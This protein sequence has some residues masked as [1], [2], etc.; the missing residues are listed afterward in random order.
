LQA[1]QSHLS[2]IVVTEKNVSLVETV[3][4]VRQAASF[5][6]NYIAFMNPGACEVVLD[7][8]VNSASGESWILPIFEPLL[9]SEM[10]RGYASS[11][12]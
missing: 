4:I 2:A 11:P 3:E 12:A 6:V 10:I 9:M 7:V 1:Q 8:C 5:P